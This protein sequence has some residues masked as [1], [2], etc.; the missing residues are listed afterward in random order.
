MAEI[1]CYDCGEAIIGLPFGVEM[2]RCDRCRKKARRRLSD[3]HSVKNAKNRGV[4]IRCRIAKPPS[5]MVHCPECVQKIGDLAKIRRAERIAAGRC[6]LCQA[7]TDGRKK[8]CV[9]CAASNRDRLRRLVRD[10][11]T[12]NLCGKCG[13]RPPVPGR[14]ACGYCAEE[15]KHRYQQIKIAVLNAYGGQQCACCGQTGLQFLALDHIDGGGNRHRAEIGEGAPFYK[16]LK[17]NS[18]PP[19]FQVLCHNCNQA[20]ALNNN[21]CPHQTG[22]SPMP[23]WD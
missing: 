15:N 7:V 9:A 12:A 10:R 20:K 21:I 17:R 23:R 1:K 13:C 22:E 18:Y 16:W 14:K 3:A 11:L 19:G 6:V 8:K 2:F 4:C 5:G